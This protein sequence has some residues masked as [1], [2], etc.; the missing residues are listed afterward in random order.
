[1]KK[2]SEARPLISLAAKGVH[3]ELRAALDAEVRAEQAKD[4]A[5]WE[6]L[7]RELEQ[8]RRDRREDGA[9]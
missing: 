9:R 1:M 2:Q 3:D 5:S 6:P 7:R 8:F 4:R